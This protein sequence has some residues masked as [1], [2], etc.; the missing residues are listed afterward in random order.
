MFY[1][2]RWSHDKIVRSTRMA[3][4]AP[5]PCSWKVYERRDHY[6][7]NTETDYPGVG[8]D[9]PEYEPRGC[10]RDRIQL[11]HILADACFVSHTH[12]VLLEMSRGQGA[13]R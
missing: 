8:P 3:S 1:R 2:D 4:T 5:D 9:S 7:G 12:R 6:L 10:P 11:V 13:T